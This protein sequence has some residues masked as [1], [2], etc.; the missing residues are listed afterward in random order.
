MMNLLIATMGDTYSRVQSNIVISNYKEIASLV[1][2]A[3]TLLIWKRSSNEKK[4]LQ[5]CRLKE[6]AS[7][8]GSISMKLK[9]MKNEIDRIS[10]ISLSNSHKLDQI[11]NKIGN[12]NK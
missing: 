10:Q 6:N 5:S 9:K 2:E 7:D 11:L 1:L 8:T 12:I 3:C 4:Y